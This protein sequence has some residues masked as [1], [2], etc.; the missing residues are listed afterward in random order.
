MH[1]G[2]W[3]WGHTAVALFSL[4]GDNPAT[5]QGCSSQVEHISRDLRL[6]VQINYMDLDDKVR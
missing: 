2:T 4:T 1:N 5:S 6:K 3:N